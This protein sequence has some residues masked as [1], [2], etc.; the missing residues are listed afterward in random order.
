MEKLNLTFRFLLDQIKEV[1]NNKR[2]RLAF[3]SYYQ[4]S[5]DD[6][7]SHL[8]KVFDYLIWR[9]IVFFILFLFLYFKLNSLYGSTIISLIG[10]SVFHLM[11]IRLRD[12]KFQQI[13]KQ[14]RRYIAGQRVYNEIMNKTSEEIEKYIKNLLR[15]IGF[16][17]FILVEGVERYLL[18]EAWY[19][20]SKV[21]VLLKLYK[22]NFDVELKEVK[23][24]IH[25]M[26][27]RNTGK[28]ILITTSDFTND[29]YDFVANLNQE[30]R[31]SRLL[32]INR[33]QFLR[34]IEE[35]H[36]FPKDE[37]IDEIIESKISRRQDRWEKYKR[38][39]LCKKKIRAYIIAGLYL[40]F[41]SFYT[42]Y[43]AYYI[44]V[45]SLI[46]I[47]ASIIFI[48]ETIYGKEIEEEKNIDLDELLAIY[49]DNI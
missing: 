1:Q 46:L 11:A 31:E 5:R 45:A 41:I 21:M 22:N 42:P 12:Y 17:K 10:V 43:T 28:G 44:G 18:L 36:L 24:F 38:S 26:T 20:G 27:S 16:S 30:D 13:K 23:E 15:I 49:R 3:K 37:E 8:A 39:A 33:E 48:L 4:E 32:L 25:T 2:N 6:K 34:I 14:K 9:V 40:I 47:L 29:S 19:K 7:R 35:N